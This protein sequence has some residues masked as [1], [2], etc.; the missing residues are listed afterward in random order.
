MIWARG[1]GGASWAASAAPSFCVRFRGWAAACVTQ[2][3]LCV[4]FR[5]GRGLRHPGTRS[6]PVFRVVSAR[7]TREEPRTEREAL[8]RERIRRSGRGGGHRGGRPRRGASASRWR[9]ESGSWRRRSARVPVST[10]AEPSTSISADAVAF[11]SASSQATKITI[12]SPSGA[13]RRP[14]SARWRYQIVLKALTTRPPGTCCATSSAAAPPSHRSTPPRGSRRPCSAVSAARTGGRPLRPRSAAHR[15]LLP[16]A[17]LQWSAP[18][19]R[20]PMPP[21]STT[22]GTGS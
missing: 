2:H 18:C 5:G 14:S 10:A 12:R 22:C 20:T 6:G 13:S 17:H 8:A 4:R 7:S 16:G 3:P 19:P 11:A 9:L 21:R 15:R 1:P